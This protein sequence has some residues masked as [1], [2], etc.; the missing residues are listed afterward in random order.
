M[1]GGGADRPAGGF[2]ASPRI[3]P[4]TPL[5]PPGPPPRSRITAEEALQDPWLLDMTSSRAAS[6]QHAVRGATPLPKAQHERVVGNVVG[7]P[8]LG[9]LHALHTTN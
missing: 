6:W 4:S 7:L 8:Q 9:V 2:R 5:P 3:Q 1:W